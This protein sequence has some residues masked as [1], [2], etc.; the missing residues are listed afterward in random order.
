VARSVSPGR[1]HLHVPAID[2]ARRFKH[3]HRIHVAAFQRRG[4]VGVKRDWPNVQC[5]LSSSDCRRSSI[6]GPMM[7]CRNNA[8]AA[9]AGDFG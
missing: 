5:S 3:D 9:A 4:A 1:S 2:Q 6:V 7:N 8:A